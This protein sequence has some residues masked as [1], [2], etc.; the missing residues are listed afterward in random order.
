MSKFIGISEFVYIFGDIF[1]WQE[2]GERDGETKPQ[3]FII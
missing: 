3:H 2:K 1:F